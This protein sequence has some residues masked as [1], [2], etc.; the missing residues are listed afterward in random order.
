MDWGVSGL[1]GAWTGGHVDWRTRGLEDRWTGEVW[2]PG[3]KI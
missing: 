1:G 3:R 2:N